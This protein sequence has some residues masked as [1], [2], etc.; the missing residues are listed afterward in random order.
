[1]IKIK[2]DKEYTLD[3]ISARK[4]KQTIAFKKK[5]DILSSQIKDKDSDVDEERLLD[6]MARYIV[7][8]FSYRKG[9][10]T[11]KP[12]TEEDIWDY[13]S[14]KDFQSKFSEIIESVISEF[15]GEVKKKTE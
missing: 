8:I 15:G 13:L 1:M 11:V 14:L 2:L 3:F 10:E 6:E 4:L 9:E 5:Y 7:D 12:F